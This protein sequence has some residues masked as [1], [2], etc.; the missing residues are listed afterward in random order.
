MDTDVDKMLENLF[1][2]ILREITPHDTTLC[3]HSSH[4]K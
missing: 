1:Y 2:F 4:F 3:G